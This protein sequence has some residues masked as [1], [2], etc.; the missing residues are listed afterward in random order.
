MV[1]LPPEKIGSFYLGAEYDIKNK[2]VTE[3]A[4]NYDAR[5]LTTHAVCVGMTG[6]GKTGLC[7]GL[8]EEAA[9]DKVPAIII[10]PKGD[11][12]NLLLQ[13]EDLDPESFKKWINPDDAARKGKTVDEYAADT[14]A[15]WKNGLADWGQDTDRI[16]RLKSAVE[17]TIY[18]PGS[19]AG[20]PINIL[21]SFAAPKFNFDD[22]AEMLYERIQGTVAALLGMVNSKE[23]PVRSREGILL[24]KLFEYYW[25][26]GE[27]LDLTKLIQGIQKPPIKQLGVFD[28]ETF[29]PEKD[30]FSLAMDFNTLVA[31][32]QFRYWLQGEPM[33]IDQ[34]YFTKEGKP[35][36]SIFY[37]AHLSESERMF[38]VT[39]LLNSLITWMRSQSGT[40]SLRSLVYFDE[41]FGYFPPTANPPSKKPLL[42]I[43]KQARAFGVGAVLVTQNPVDIDYKGLSNAGTWFIGKLQTERDKMRVLDGLKG[44]IA[45]KGGNEPME[46]NHIIS[47]LTSRVFLYH[48]VH[49]GQ[50]KLLH[51]RWAMS[52]LRG[53]LTRSQIKLLMA[54]KK[55]TS[56]S[57]STKQ[58]EGMG[59]GDGRNTLKS[60]SPGGVVSTNPP[61]LDSSID[62]KFLGVWKSESEA[63][64]ELGTNE[65]LKIQYKPQI[66]A[67]GKVR[68]YDAKREIDQVRE[69]AV[70]SAA[71]DDFGRSNWESATQLND[72][73]RM[74]MSKPDH[75]QS[76]SISYTDIPDTLNTSKEFT[77][78][79]KDYSDYLYQN[80]KLGIHEHSDLKISQ[81]SGETDEAFMMRC[82]H[83]AREIRDEEMDDLQDKYE[84]KFDRIKD[85]IRREEHDMDQ[86]KSELSH[87]RTAEIMGVAETIFSVFVKRRS[88]SMSA[89]SSKSRMRKKASN[90]LA[91]SKDD[92]LEL[93]DDH[94]ALESELRSKLEEIQSKWDNVQAAIVTKVITPRRT[95]VKVDAIIFTWHPYWSSS[96]G[97]IVSAMRS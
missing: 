23:D 55:K 63:K 19:N 81:N 8:L 27:D 36:H 62:T 24:A 1:G 3:E 46:F 87:R 96:S 40:T 58:V 77:A 28:V 31:S 39:L 51:T 10:D 75:P 85:R 66:L 57:Q 91:E 13:F 45:E 60:A 7:I 80:M 53:P 14:A 42:T 73:E 72:W 41:I 15:M 59:T 67:S 90:K 88:R 97:E 54:E 48:N 35:K 74:L 68:F 5:D 65:N 16:K 47:A 93:Q 11:M 17:Y 29:Y 18:T 92:L 6:S 30:R 61:S 69:V 9:I 22:D 78:V 4:I 34:I 44:A 2:A 38:F 20:I 26:K 37:I 76:V 84:P 89:A 95:D 21:G 33:D 56:R 49:E 94:K 70:L 86:A 52:Y 43:L 50:P 83:A 25:R 32:P 64:S 82:Q 12:T 71:P 79:E